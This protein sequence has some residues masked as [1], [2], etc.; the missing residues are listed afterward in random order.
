MRVREGELEG[1]MYIDKQASHFA[2]TRIEWNRESLQLSTFICP[3]GVWI[4]NVTRSN[5]LQPCTGVSGFIIISKGVA[6]RAYGTT[7]FCRARCRE[8]VVVLE[9]VI[10]YKAPSASGEIVYPNSMR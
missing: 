8:V 5:Q 10:H 1:T 7:G 3:K 2:A 4:R 9:L 6:Q